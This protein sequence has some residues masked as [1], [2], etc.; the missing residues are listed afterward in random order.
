MIC[1]FTRVKPQFVK[2]EPQNIECRRVESLRLTLFKK[3]EFIH[4]MFDVGRSM[5]DVNQYGK[6][7]R[8]M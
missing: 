1:E 7:V 5:F 6:K 4:S 2:S 3:A 8:S